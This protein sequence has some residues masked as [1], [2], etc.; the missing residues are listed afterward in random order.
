MEE[1]IFKPGEVIL[2]NG[3]KVTVEQITL[4]YGYANAIYYVDED[5]MLGMDREC[6]FEKIINN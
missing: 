3:E 1:S 4:S 2:L 5:G 6:N